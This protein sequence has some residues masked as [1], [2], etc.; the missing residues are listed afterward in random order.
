MSATYSDL[1]GKAGVEIHTGLLRVMRR[2]F[3]DQQQ[4]ENTVGAYYDLIAALRSHTWRLL[5]PN[6]VR[7]M[8]LLD[9]ADNPGR[10][11]LDAI[12]VR[13]FREFGSLR[14]R[15]TWMP[16][17]DTDFD[18]PWRD[19]AEKLGAA[20]D[21][22]DTHLAW[23]GQGLSE[24]APTVADPY[25]RRGALAF[26]AQLTSVTVGA[27]AAI[28]AACRHRDIPWETV[29]RWFPDRGATKDLVHRMYELAA[30]HEQHSGLR[31]VAVNLYPVREGDPIQELG[32]RMLRLRHA[33]WGLAGTDPDYSVVTLHDLAGLGMT[34]N[35]HTAAAH[36]IDV[37]GRTP[38]RHRLV[39]SAHAFLQLT[40]DL[41]E[42]V[43]PGPPDPA[44][45]TDVLAA[46][47]L[48][49]ELAPTDQPAR[50]LQVADPQTRNTLSA[51]HGACDV[52]GQIARM[53]AVTFGTLAR[54]EQIHIPTRLLTGE[55]LSDEPD[56]AEA[57][58]IGV[59]RVLA[60]PARL[61]QTVELYDAVSKATAHVDTYQ[62]AQVHATNYDPPAL[63]RR[64]EFEGRP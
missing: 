14:E 17:P 42:Y 61:R 23:R 1:V 40:A 62:P 28:G 15:P 37:T 26:I 29:N 8:D 58:L 38:A 32:D 31:D 25:Q 24:Q 22:L 13:T 19:A 36:G 47:R 30:K 57:K 3:V 39:V 33:A 55:I 43:A 53:N 11:D 12:A 50:G 41:R 46:C 7:T 45:R 60:P 6:R 51:L 34:A 35:L 56:I 10:D 54:S 27:D 48:L 52:V 4:A 9:A 44:I 2:G 63:F 20:A 18:H 21:L 5:D 16:Y 59:H 64:T 49:A